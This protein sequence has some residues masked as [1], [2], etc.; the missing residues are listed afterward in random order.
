M[1]I[2][3][4]G[5][6]GYIGSH[7]VK[8]LA[9]A[10]HRVV[11]LDNHLSGHARIERYAQ[12]V[13]G[14]VANPTLVRELLRA[15]AF[16]AVMHFASHIEVAESVVDPG[17]YYANNFA[18]TLNLLQAM[19]ETGVRRF[20]FSSTAAIYG[21]PQRTPIDETHPAAPINPYG[22]SKW[23]VEQ[24]LA[25]FA[26]A[27]A[28]QYACLRY[29]NAA[30]AD[31]DGEFGECHEPESHLIPLVLR[32]ASGRRDAITVFGRD[33]PT[34]DGTCERDYIHVSDLADAHLAALDYLAAGGEL[35]AFN[36]G[37]GIGHTVQEIIDSAHAV[38][39]RPI[40][41]RDASR[42]AGDP[43]SLVADPRLALR[44]LQWKPRL[45]DLPTVLQHAWRWE[46]KCV[47]SPA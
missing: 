42:R 34:R 18:A 30:G 1:N 21:N 47:Q 19:H 5:G 8:R 39:A 9:H 7:M 40:Q 45:S 24:V 25:D 41:V 43:A 35:R 36:L 46:L 10:G 20:I 44:T 15:H 4:V 29:F 13:D 16:D 32:A 6:A 31:P 23:M 33:Y 26:S 37:T 38:C 3:V 14:D 17:K 11:V 12:S 27:H 22:R 28:L 2:L